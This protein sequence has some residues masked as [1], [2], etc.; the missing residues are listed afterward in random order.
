VSLL[1]RWEAEPSRSKGER[2]IKKMLR[3]SSVREGNT[4]SLLCVGVREWEK[5]R[6]LEQ[7]SKYTLAFRA[8]GTTKL[9]IFFLFNNRVLGL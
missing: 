4:K 9:Y 1:A 7:S 3:S 2:I 8:R 6:I 5:G